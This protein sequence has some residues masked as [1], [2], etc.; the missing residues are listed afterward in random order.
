M[1]SSSLPDI[2]SVRK[3][4][5]EHPGYFFYIEECAMLYDIFQDPNLLCRVLQPQNRDKIYPVLSFLHRCPGTL[6]F[7][8]DY[9][10]VM[11]TT[12]LCKEL[13]NGKIVYE[14]YGYIETYVL[15][16]PEVQKA[17][18]RCWKERNFP[19]ASSF[20]GDFCLPIAPK[21]PE[22]IPDSEMDGYS[23]RWL[24]S[25]REYVSAGKALSN[26]LVSWDVECQPVLTVAPLS[27][28]LT[29]NPIA[30]V[31]VEVYPGNDITI[32]Q[33][34]EARNRRIEK[35]SPLY[36]ALHKWCERFNVF[37]NE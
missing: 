13:E 29:K 30:A 33:A 35:G 5:L 28:G 6:K 37:W 20:H 23:F 17:E 27:K 16:K 10:E 22:D 31:E 26:C 11:G 9:A 19:F 8:Q 3:L 12:G 34:F 14:N 25:E 21:P 18:Q 24:R 4:F 2:K 7:Y 32:T 36:L 15:S 1:K